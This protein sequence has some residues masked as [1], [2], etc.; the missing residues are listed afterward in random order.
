MQVD[1]VKQMNQ[2]AQSIHLEPEPTSEADQE[3]VGQ[4]SG[5]ELDI[6]IIHDTGGGV[7]SLSDFFGIPVFRED[8]IQIIREY[9]RQLDAQLDYISR[10]V[11]LRTEETDDAMLNYIQSQLF[12]D[13]P[14]IIR[15]PVRDDVRTEGMGNMIFAIQIMAVVFTLLMIGYVRRRSKKRR[16]KI[17]DINHF[18]N[19]A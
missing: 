4:G 19:T 7:M 2:I 9:E 11:F 15:D 13:W 14:M 16:E 8:N 3:E 5:L 12:L 1:K 18:G 10:E 17:N 6:T